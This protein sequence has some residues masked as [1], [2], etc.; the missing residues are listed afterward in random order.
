MKPLREA[1]HDG[2]FAVTA[3]VGPPKGT[4]TSAFFDRALLLRERVN[5]V[6]VTDNQGS[7]MRL[8]PLAAC[9][10]LAAAG[11]DSVFQLTCRD[12]NRLALQSDLLGASAVGVRNVLAL[13]GDFI[14][15][16]DHPEAKPVFDIDSTHLL[17]VITRLNSGFD[18]KGN[19]LAGLPDLFP[20]AVVNP[21]ATPIE[22]QL[23]RFE[24]KMAAGAR[25]FQ[26]QAVFDSEGLKRVTDMAEKRGAKVLAGIILLRSAKMAEFLN[27]NI[28]GVRV[29]ERFI[30][31]LE[32]SPDPARTGVEIAA[33]LVEEFRKECHGVHIMALGNGEKVIDILDESGL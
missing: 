27:R 9:A 21:S 31:E 7:V 15:M 18:M 5:A 28:P 2:E 8:S 22:P 3:E 4:D 24:K 32:R 10:V 16:G 26:T 1:L 6:N 29:P 11:I 30:G 33:G 12:R 14:T 17:Q 25:F 19:R 13:T 23:L 20:G